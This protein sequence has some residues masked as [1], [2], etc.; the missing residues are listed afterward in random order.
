RMAKDWYMSQ[1]T[2]NKNNGHSENL[3][4]NNGEHK[5]ANHPVE[6]K[7]GC[8][9]KNTEEYDETICSGIKHIYI[10]GLNN[11]SF[12]MSSPRKSVHESNN[13]L[14]DSES[15]NEIFRNQCLNRDDTNYRVHFNNNLEKDHEK[16]CRNQCEE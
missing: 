3:R 16:I 12:I 11:N 4:F 8:L 7:T 14:L 6:F 9:T 15:E 13:S 2:M 5:C 1:A 10:N